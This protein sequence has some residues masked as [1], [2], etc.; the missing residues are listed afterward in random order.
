MQ[1]DP[2]QVFARLKLR[3]IKKLFKSEDSRFILA[4]GGKITLITLIVMMFVAYMLWVVISVNNVFFEANGYLEIIEL[5][6]AYFDFILTSTLYKFHYYLAFYIVLFLMGIYV[7]RILMRPFEIIGA[8][9]E[10]I[11]ENK[12]DTYNPDLFSDFKL[13]TRFSE[14]FFQYLQESRRKGELFQSTIPP[15]FSKIHGPVFDRVFFFHF[16]L[17]ISIISIVA[18]SVIIVTTVEI[19]ESIVDLAIQ[20]LSNKSTVEGYF[21][22]NQTYIFESIQYVTVGTMIFSY[23]ALGFHLYSKVAGA[24]FGFFSTMRSYMKGNH[25]ARVHLVGYSHIRPHSRALNKYLDYMQKN[26]SEE[27]KEK[28]SK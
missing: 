6:Q 13:L 11:I 14:F 16:M 15:Q 1:F 25:Y 2:K 8:Y 19:H 22:K 10:S 26:Y 18:G 5:R 3:N 12:G 7:G 24:V 4:T 21:L 23:I 9:C 27:F 17:F 20:T 28:D